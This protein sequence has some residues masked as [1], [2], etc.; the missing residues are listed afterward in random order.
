MQIFRKAQT[1]SASLTDAEQWIFGTFLYSLFL[2]YH[3]A[4]QL[5]KR[6]PH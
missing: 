3:Q 4:Y 5:T 2:D 6:I 1:E